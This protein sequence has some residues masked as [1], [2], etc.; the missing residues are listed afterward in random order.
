MGMHALCA[1]G[2][3]GGGGIQHKLLL[4]CPSSLLDEEVHV[5]FANI[6]IA[7]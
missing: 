1:G 2:G 7:G 3:G 5:A 6:L 4:P